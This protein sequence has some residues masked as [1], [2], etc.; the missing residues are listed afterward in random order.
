M[1]CNKM[2]V[3]N[4]K[5]PPLLHFWHYDTVN[6]FNA[7]QIFSRYVR[8]ILRFTKQEADVQTNRSYLPQQAIPERLKRFRE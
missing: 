5:G 3:K 4:S 6:I 7:I 2:D 1:L 8:T